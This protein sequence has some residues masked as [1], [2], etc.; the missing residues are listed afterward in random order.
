MSLFAI[1][2]QLGFAAGPII[3][4]AALNVWGLKGTA[5]LL[6]PPI[7]MGALLTYMLPRLTEGYEPKTRTP[8]RTPA[9]A[10]QGRDRWP[11]FTC[12]AVALL[13]RSVVFYGLNTFLPLFWINELHQSRAR[14]GGA[15][16]TMLVAMMAGNFMGGRTADRLGLRTVSIA[17]F[18]FLACFLPALLF[19][20]SPLDGDPAS[21]PR[22]CN[23]LGAVR[24][25]GRARPV[26]PAPQGRS[27]LGH[28]PRNSLLIWRPHDTP[29]RVGRRSPRASRVDRGCRVHAPPLSRPHFGAAVGEKHKSGRKSRFG[30]D[31]F[32]KQSTDW[33]AG[34][35]FSG[36][37]IAGVTRVPPWD[38]WSGAPKAQGEDC[39]S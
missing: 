19:V 32:S 28:H 8:S 22:G 31:P 3:A 29:S 2:G 39:L 11:A 15:L 24:T 6:V 12:L 26:L 21:G 23:A 13:S 38:G 30:L 14:A 25:H 4:T 27:C 36:A 33:P 9:E 37:S 20:S 1:G 35:T 5:C 18:F 17:G 34:G 16:T 10:P 7:I